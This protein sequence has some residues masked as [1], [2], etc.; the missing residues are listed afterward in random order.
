MRW[1]GK[2]VNEQYAGATISI[3]QVDNTLHVEGLSTWRDNIAD[4][5]LIAIIEGNQLTTPDTEDCAVRIIYHDDKL[6][7]TE[8]EDCSAGLNVSFNGTYTKISR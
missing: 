1:V 8:Q 2:W 7:V 3:A 4:L 6:Q 5:D